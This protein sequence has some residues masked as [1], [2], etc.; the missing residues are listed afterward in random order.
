MVSIGQKPRSAESGRQESN[1]A[2]TA[3]RERATGAW[4]GEAAVAGTGCASRTCEN[5]TGCCAK[6]AAQGIQTRDQSSLAHATDWQ[7]APDDEAA[8][9]GASG[10]GGLRSASA[11]LRPPCVP[12]PPEARPTTTDQGDIIS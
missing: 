5:Q 2:A 7:C 8:A 11:T 1:R 3:G 9:R 6:G 10:G 12:P 4:R